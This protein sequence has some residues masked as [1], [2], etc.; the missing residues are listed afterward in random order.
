MDEPQRI[1]STFWAG[2]ITIKQPPSFVHKTAPTTVEPHT[3]KHTSGVGDI[4]FWS[5]ECF[6]FFF[7]FLFFFGGG[8]ST[9][10]FLPK[11]AC[12]NPKEAVCDVVHV[13]LLKLSG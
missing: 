1:F 5:R 2:K 4:L 3:L 10:S 13:S 8:G 7:F 6:S 9:R 11:Q 12:P